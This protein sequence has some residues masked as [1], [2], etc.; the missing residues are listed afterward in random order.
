MGTFARFP[1]PVEAD[2]AWVPAREPSV[3]PFSMW[4]RSALERIG[5]YRPTGLASDT[6]LAWRLLALGDV[7]ILDDVVGSYR[8]HDSATGASIENGRVQA[9][10]SQLIAVSAR[11][12][13][14]GLVDI[15]FATD[16]NWMARLRAAGSLGRMLAVAVI[17][18]ELSGEEI[19][20]MEVAVAAK[21]LQWFE[22]RRFLPESED[23]VFIRRAYA[24]TGRLQRY[25]QKE[26]KRL[27]TVAAARLL[28]A[29]HLR[30]AAI[31][32]PPRFT[33]SALARTMLG[34]C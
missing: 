21:M 23:V 26:L 7:T 13:E 25:N 28:R 6:D 12:R 16:R 32:T 14:R 1:P 20:F 17:T 15:E 24:L 19:L 34:R 27:Y 18:A 30:N 31:L 11:R 9:V 29:K 33:G 22:W 10:C 8:V 3:M 2:A 5:G 4:R